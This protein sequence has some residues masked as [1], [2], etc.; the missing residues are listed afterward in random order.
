MTS[1]ASTY[2]PQTSPSKTNKTKAKN[3]IVK[4]YHHE[5]CMTYDCLASKT[6]SN[7][8]DS[9][10]EETQ[11]LLSTMRLNSDR[12]CV[13]SVCTK[14][15]RAT[16]TKYSIG[17]IS[18]VD[19]GVVSHDSL[20]DRYRDMNGPTRSE[21]SDSPCSR[22]S[23]ASRRSDSPVRGEFDPLNRPVL[24]DSKI[25]SN[26]RSRLQERSRGRS[27][28]T[29]GVRQII[30]FFEGSQENLI[31]ES[32]TSVLVKGSTEPPAIK[33]PLY[34]KSLSPLRLARSRRNSKQKGSP[35]AS[36]SHDDASP[37]SSTRSRQESSLRLTCAASGYS[38]YAPSFESTN[39]G[40]DGNISNL[41]STDPNCSTHKLNGATP[42]EDDIAISDNSLT[43]GLHSPLDN[44]VNTTPQDHIEVLRTT[45]E[46]NGSVDRSH[47]GTCSHN[48]AADIKN[49]RELSAGD[50]DVTI[51]DHAG[52]RVNKH[53]S[54][55][56]IDQ[57]DRAELT[58]P[59]RDESLPTPSI[60]H[61]K[62]ETKHIN[63]LS[64]DTS[65]D[66]PSKKSGKWFL[67]VTDLAEQKLL[68]MCEKVEVYLQQ[69]ELSEEVS[70]QI[71]AATGKAHLLVNKKFKQF[72]D[73]CNKNLTQGPDEPFPTTSQ[74]LAGFW[75]L[76][77]IQVENC[78]ASFSD[79]DTL[80]SNGWM[81][82]S[83][84]NAS[85]LP[86]KI[87]S[88]RG[89]KSIAG[90][91]AENKNKAKTSTTKPAGAAKARDEARK[92]LMA[93]K[94]AMKERRNSETDDVIFVMAN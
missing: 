63:S 88:P 28:T 93:A 77:N 67:N 81:P 70:G 33:H 29:H 18:A 26:S 71:R 45:T 85:D 80:R 24:L 87:A 68:S 13:T 74:D 10:P 64:E 78:E 76:V 11:H 20:L 34:T 19:S 52:D 53:I 50:V 44:G 3:Q 43:N 90:T 54:N 91:L 59:L 73:L 30:N 4:T 75:D 49:N 69:E 65:Q 12:S 32:R 42:T 15:D 84:P 6:D 55:G 94:K 37:A 72:R 51:V 82:I 48:H 23:T 16:A 40:G 62:L 79:I 83:I 25:R 56:S 46:V 35:T 61:S 60:T 92:R 39:G 17:G 21:R 89:N 14:S 58:L 7:L 36:P 47:L 57:V 22:Y 31:S 86:K 1:S 66:S 2:I 9:D 41:N 5:I 27:P 8:Y 38:P